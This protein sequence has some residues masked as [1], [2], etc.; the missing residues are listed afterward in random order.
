MR[1]NIWEHWAST[2]SARNGRYT[3]GRRHLNLEPLRE[4][5]CRRRRSRRAERRIKTHQEKD[6]KRTGGHQKREC[7][8]GLLGD[9]LCSC[10]CACACLGVRWP[11]ALPLSFST[12][13]PLH[14]TPITYARRTW[15]TQRI[16]R[17]EH[18]PTTR[19]SFHLRCCASTVSGCGEK[20]KAVS[21]CACV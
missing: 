11:L 15:P 7:V 16:R 3:A 2:E 6:T 17:R 19:E 14:R 18:V 8:V 4:E 20:E 13:D 10:C 12:V 21:E 1:T 5:Y 9:G